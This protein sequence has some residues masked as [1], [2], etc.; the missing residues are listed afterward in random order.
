[1]NISINL[2]P[3]EFRE[4]EL[5]RAKFYKIQTLGVIVILIVIFLT[6]L[7]IALRILQS[8]NIKVVQANYT[9]AGEKVSGLKNRQAS[10]L[11]L[12]NRLAAINQYLDTPSKQ[13][14]IFK[15][16]SEILPPQIVV[17]SLNVEK[18]GDVSIVA[19]A[20]D[21]LTLDTAFENL[22]DQQQ[23]QDKISQVSIENLS[24]SRDGLFRISFRIKTK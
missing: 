9:Q 17:T 3:L 8:Q 15:L 23:N 7:T 18:T 16:I 11:L 5:K 12:K 6:S 19:L 2:L 4:Q 10:L 13:N 22:L 21:T 14:A 24:R 20:P 1:M